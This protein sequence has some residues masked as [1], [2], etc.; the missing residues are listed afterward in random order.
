MKRI[1]VWSYHGSDGNVYHVLPDGMRRSLNRKCKNERSRT[2]KF[3]FSKKWGQT[4]DENSWGEEQTIL[5]G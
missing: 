2:P 3:P 5:S 4:S 1:I